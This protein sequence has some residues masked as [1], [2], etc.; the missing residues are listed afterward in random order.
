MPA[1][2][3]KMWKGEIKIADI[4]AA[5]VIKKLIFLSRVYIN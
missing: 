4:N 5:D 1:E 3:I 2:Q